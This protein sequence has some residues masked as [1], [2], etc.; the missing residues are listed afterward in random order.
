MPLLAALVLAIIAFALL[1]IAPLVVIGLFLLAF[2][3]LNQ[4]EK[5]QV[6]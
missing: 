2:A 4:I 5:G 6:D 3:V 1:N